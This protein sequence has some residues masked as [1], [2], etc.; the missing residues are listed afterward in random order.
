MRLKSKELKI[1]FELKKLKISMDVNW[2][3]GMRF[4]PTDEELIN[5]YLWV[6]LNDRKIHEGIIKELNIYDY[7]PYQLQSKYG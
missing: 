7:E 6:R 4:I 5:N 3:I 1:G 2:N